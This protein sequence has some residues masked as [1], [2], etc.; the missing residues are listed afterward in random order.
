MALHRLTRITI[1]VPNLDET[2]AYYADFGLRATGEHTFATADGGEQLRLVHSPSR[3]LVDLG[4][5]VDD[6]DDVARIEASL[7]R[8]GLSLD[9]H[10]TVT[11]PGTGVRVKVEIAGHITRPAEPAPVYNGPGR[12]DRLDARAPGVLREERV[13]PRK[14]GHVVLGST[15]Q[16]ASQRFFTEGLGFKVSDEVPGIAAFLRCSSDHHNV[17]VQ[18]APVP[19]L[20]HTSWEVEDVDEIGRGAHHMLE[21]HPERHVWGLGRHHIGS[22]FFWYLKDPAGNFSEYYSDLDCVVDEAV[23]KPEVFSDMRILYSW[24]PPVPPSFIEPED[25]AAL[26]AGNHE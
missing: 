6:P 2:A 26:M 12:A 21:G 10:G 22:N 8:L 3:R 7:A 13:R 9:G 18:P 17:L 15:D 16:E 4:V 5:G 1:G 20:H 23:W 11:D 14:L 24:G 19:Y 25:L